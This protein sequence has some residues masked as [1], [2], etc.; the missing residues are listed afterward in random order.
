MA[1]I[2]LL[3]PPGKAYQRS[4]DRA[5]CNL[6]ESAVATIHACNDLGCAAAVL[7]QRGYEVLLRDYQTERKSLEEVREDISR[8]CP[9]GILLS[10]TNATILT[11]IA[12]INTIAQICSCKWIVKGAIFFDIPM[13]LLDTLDLSNIH[14][15]IGGEMD[16]IIGDL[17]DCILKNTGS[18][19]KIPGI[20][21]RQADTFRKTDFAAWSDRLD[22]IPFPA[23]DLMKNELYPRPDTGEPMATVQVSRGCPSRCTYCLTPIISGNRLRKRSVENVFAEIR[24]CYYRYGIRSFFF[25]ADTFTIDETWA[26]ALCDRIIA[27][28]LWGKIAFTV[29]SRA[30]PLSAGLLKKLKKAGCFMVAVGF[31]SGSDDTLKKIRKG[32]TREDNLR[33]AR[34]IREAGLPLFGFFMI[35]FPWETEADILGTLKFMLAVDPDFVEVHIAMPYYGT[36]LYEQCMQYGTIAAAAWGNDYFSPNT[37]GTQTVPMERIQRLRNRYLLKFYLRPGYLA[38]KMYQCLRRPVIFKNYW[39]HGIRLLKT[40]FRKRN[41]SGDVS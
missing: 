21:Y 41:S 6:E 9:D 19:E 3:Y 34:M 25:R 29:N 28:E 18:L 24:E 37:I 8:F 5:Q 16:V 10:T 26:G 40:I 15:L 12:F 1:K 36:V 13:A 4:E 23:R 27:S 38:K 7:R 17:V 20:L 35:G 32:T 31:E 39:K 33:A 30:K 2:M 11:D 14:C 22:E